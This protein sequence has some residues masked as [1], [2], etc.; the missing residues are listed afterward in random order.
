MLSCPSARA[1][2]RVW[3]LWIALLCVALCV[4]VLASGCSGESRSSQVAAR[5]ATPVSP[6]ESPTP[7]PTPPPPDPAL[8]ETFRYNG[9]YD[10]AQAVYE[11][12][13]ERGTL[14][15][16]QDAR[17]SLARLL[18][19]EERYEEA[20]GQLEA[21][22]EEA[23]PTQDVGSARFLLAAAVGALGETSRAIVLYED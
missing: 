15:M 4:F 7:S 20:Q 22:L 23:D 3:A 19:D 14:R 8:A 17:L 10:E 1:A 12:I 21:Y 9:E 6:V 11:A 18:L 2:L 5:S 13:I 16:R